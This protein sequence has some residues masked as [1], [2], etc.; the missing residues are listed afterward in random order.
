[1]SGQPSVVF[2]MGATAVGKSIFA[3][4]LA[5]EVGAKIV[6]CDSVQ[7]YEGPVI[8]ANSPSE[9]DKQEVDHHLYSYV[10]YPHELTTGDYRR[11]F[12]SVLE[13]FKSEEK[14]LVVGGTGFY[15]QAIERGMYKS[16]TIPAEV[17]TQVQNDI[18][19]D[20]I[21]P[22]VCDELRVGDPEYFAQININDR[23]RVGRAL[24]ILRS[25]AKMSDLKKT[26]DAEKFP[27]PLFKTHIVMDRAQL[28]AK[29]RDRSVQMLRQG[30]VEETRDLRQRFS[31]SWAP[32]KAVGYFEAQMMLDL[33]KSSD[34]L[35]DEI[36]LRTTQLVK[37]QVTWFK[38]LPEV[39]NFDGGVDYKK[40]RDSCLRFWNS[41][42]SINTRNQTK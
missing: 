5:V 16:V 37:K 3:Q 7:V 13:N 40:F 2:V 34:W 19:D 28:K 36:T 12:F 15:F 35:I 30:L 32:L 9:Q 41:K 4:Q 33:N 27:Y 10:S 39:E 29:I 38:R 21:Y 1:V 25:G 14:I 22:K 23:Y 20:L 17:T 24:E 31:A 11:D 8:G 18:K 6:N 26:F 42:G